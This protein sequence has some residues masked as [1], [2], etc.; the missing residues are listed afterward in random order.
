V[1]NWEKEQEK[2]WQTLMKKAHGRL[3]QAG[4]PPDA[5]TDRFKPKYCDVAEDILDEAESIGVDTIVMGRR[6][7]GKAK[8]LLLGSVTNKV[9]QKARGCVVTIV[10]NLRPMQKILVPL[11]LGA[12]NTTII[13]LVQDL[14]NKFHATVL[15]LYVAPPVTMF[16]SF[17]VNIDIASFEAEMELAAREQM[18][19]LVNNFFQDFPRMETRVEVGSPAEE[20]L[21]VARQENIDMILMGTHDRQGLERAIFGSVAFKV[22]QAAPCTIVTRHP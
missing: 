3:T 8:A 10:S 21:E 4:F 13:P 20:I 15:L 1:G 11:D 2:Q 6:G 7:L 5:V 12:D 17:Y 14:A 18:A 16:P 22:V 19:A 9:A